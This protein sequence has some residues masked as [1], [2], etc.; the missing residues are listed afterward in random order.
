MDDYKLHR[1]YSAIGFL[2][3]GA[4]GTN[5]KS[6]KLP[7]YPPSAR[8]RTDGK[9]IVGQVNPEELLHRIT[10]NYFKLFLLLSLIMMRLPWIRHSLTSVILQNSLS[11]QENRKGDL[12]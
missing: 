10:I 7:D 11:S 4:Y 5:P 1:M 12:K 9:D 8:T 3:R 6:L 2:Q